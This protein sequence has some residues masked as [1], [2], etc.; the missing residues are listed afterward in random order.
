MKAY[1]VSDVSLK[2][3]EAV[4]AYRERAAASIEQYGGRYLVRG[5]G[6]TPIEGHWSPEML[7]IVEFPDRERAE[8]WYHSAE[9]G[10]ALE[11]RD[12]AL[13]RS[14]IIVDGVDPAG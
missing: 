13:S 14:L 6:I 4:R 10:A 3:P 5:K 7:V 1:V 12:R 2:D 8:R 11:Y 9:Y